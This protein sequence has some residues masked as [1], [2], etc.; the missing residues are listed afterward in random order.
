MQRNILKSLLKSS[1][2]PEAA[3]SVELIQTHVSWIFLAGDMAYK[4]K[5]PV[6]FGFLNFSTIDRRRFY[7]HEEVRLN[8][9]LCPD[10]YLGVVEVREAPG[11]AAFFGDGPVIDY[12][13]KM[14]RLPAERMLDRLVARGEVTADDMRAVAR[15]IAAFHLAAATSPAIGEYGRRERIMANWQENFAQSTAGSRTPLSPD[16]LEVI[17]EWVSS[18]AESRGE[19]FEKR[20]AQGFI[21]ECDGDIHLENICLSDGRICIFDCIEFNERFRYCD[22]AADIAFL[23]MDLDYHRRRDLAEAVLDAYLA[24]SGDAGLPEIVDFYKL[25]RAFVRGKVESFRQSDNGIE[26]QEQ[27]RAGARAAGYFRLARGYIERQRLGT[28]LFI[29]CGPTGSGKSTL[30]AQLAFELGIATF[31]SDRVRKQMAALPPDTAMRVPFETGLY[32]AAASEATY[33]ELLRLA[34]AE[35]GAGRSVIIDAC[36]ISR[37][38]RRP[39]SDLAE[40]LA[41]RCVVLNCVCP[42]A[43]HRRRLVARETAGE[44]ISDG[45]LEILELQCANFQP[46][47]K[48][49][50]LVVNVATS[51]APEALASP[52]YARLAP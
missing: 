27:E 11:G 4:V 17:R 39:F 48:S 7:C 30:A 47:D 50:G 15:V 19:L 13:V 51:A 41:V 10:I 23:L 12:A 31:N 18:F 1:A 38:Q 16:E 24:A 45:R 42:E 20:V 25:Y 43:E 8:S 28:T 29:T 21:R 2:Y 14:K 33:A 44:S 3:D 5:K 9:R 35:L 49:E 34:E 6:D 32:S 36:F 46:P 22:T 26:T 52:I 37:G 40:R